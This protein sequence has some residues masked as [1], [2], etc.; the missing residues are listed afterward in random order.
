MK[1][2]NTLT[3]IKENKSINKISDCLENNSDKIKKASS[4]AAGVFL[5][6]ITT[7]MFPTTIKSLRS[8]KSG[9]QLINLK[10]VKT[11]LFSMFS[12]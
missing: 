11:S 5:I 7:L 1:K 9:Q 6:Y 4:I 2:I 8:L 3:T 10:G 12:K